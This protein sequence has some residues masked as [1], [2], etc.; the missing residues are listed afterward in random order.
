MTM[1]VVGAVGK[2]AYPPRRSAFTA[3]FWSALAEGRFQT[4]RCTKCAK[5]SFPPKPICPHCWSDE[6][7]WVVLTGRGRLYSRTTVHAGP[8]AFQHE[9]PYQ[10]GIVDLDEGLRIAT[11]IL[12]EA[13]LDQ[14]VEIVVLRYEDGDIYAAQPVRAG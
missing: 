7:E 10:V 8:A 4:T 1:T 9:L 6:T 14:P 13:E 2:R 11:R 5:P 12:G 3:T